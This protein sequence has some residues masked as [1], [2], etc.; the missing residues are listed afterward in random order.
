MLYVYIY[1]LLLAWVVSPTWGAWL[2]WLNPPQGLGLAERANPSRAE[3][4]AATS[5]CRDAWRVHLG[6]RRESDVV[7][8][9]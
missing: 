7:R 8:P 3:Q 2:P 9:G 5:Q 4:T 1:T 6:P